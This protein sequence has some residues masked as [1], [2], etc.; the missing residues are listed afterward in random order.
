M[1]RSQSFTEPIFCND[2]KTNGKILVKG[3]TDSRFQTGLYKC[4][5]LAALYLDHVFRRDFVLRVSRSESQICILS[6]LYNI[7]V[8]LFW[9]I[10]Y[11]KVGSQR[12][13]EIFVMCP[14][15]HRPPKGLFTHAHFKCFLWSNSYLIVKRSGVNQSDQSS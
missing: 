7:K 2:P 9:I 6:I 15:L 11:S 13:F 10:V 1:I 12:V 8:T 4:I 3:T 5:I 14:V